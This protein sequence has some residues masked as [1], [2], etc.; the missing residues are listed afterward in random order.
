[1]CFGETLVKMEMFLLLSNLL[2][3]YKI[4]FPKEFE[5]P[6]DGD[7]YFNGLARESPLYQAVFTER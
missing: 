4:S 7:I 5:A 6:E 2:L 1:M 3:K